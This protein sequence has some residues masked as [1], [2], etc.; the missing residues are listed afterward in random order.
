ME[1]LQ[2]HT[3]LWSHKTVGY[4]NYSP[5]EQSEYKFQHVACFTASDPP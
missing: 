1:H 5:A 4:Y 2:A 3:T